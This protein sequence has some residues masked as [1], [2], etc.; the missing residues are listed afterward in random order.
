[1]KTLL[2]LG[3]LLVAVTLMVT[4]SGTAQAQGTELARILDE[5]VRPVWR[6]YSDD[7]T[8]RE[9]LRAYLTEHRKRTRL[10][11]QNEVAR[12][13]FLREVF[14]EH[15]KRWWT[16]YDDQIRQ[17]RIKEYWD[18]YYAG[19]DY[20]F[21]L[22]NSVPGNNI[23]KLYL[24]TIDDGLNSPMGTRIMDEAFARGFASAA[25]ECFIDGLL[26][27]LKGFDKQVEDFKRA[28]FRI[29][30]KTRLYRPD[31][32]EREAIYQRLAEGLKGQ[33]VSS[34][35]NILPN[36]KR[37]LSLE[38]AALQRIRES[39]KNLSD[40]IDCPNLRSQNGGYF[41]CNFRVIPAPYELDEKAAFRLLLDN[42][43][44][45]PF[46]PRIV[47]APL[48]RATR[49]YLR[50]V[51]PNDEFAMY[52][53][54]DMQESFQKLQEVQDSKIDN[55]L[56]KYAYELRES[57]N[58]FRLSNINLW[59]SYF[60]KAQ[61]E[62]FLELLFSIREKIK[63]YERLELGTNLEKQILDQVKF[64]YTEV[65]KSAAEISI[66]LQLP[67]RE[68]VLILD[69]SVQTY[70]ELPVRLPSF[71]TGYLLGPELQ[72][73]RYWQQILSL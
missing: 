61:T 63:R 19:K 58:T 71:P 57:L 64:S 48:L 4:N 66:N 68:I 50:A 6:P 5:E 30:L 70:L 24:Q 11:I 44:V 52:L 8:E 67:E 26:D 56:K 69:D 41:N 18:S 7:L 55:A 15:T 42:Q 3:Q 35:R 34:V 29:N 37:S 62:K 1:M 25:P 14:H 51:R 32:V 33:M 2:R 12:I 17:Q 46:Q 10:E 38:G 59:R 21:D 65:L 40:Y 36:L 72:D 27:K 47:I 23:C 16:N 54:N 20:A 28:L 39:A 53:V 60:P 9:L 22:L 73:A 13:N 49:W 45:G 31:E 43:Q